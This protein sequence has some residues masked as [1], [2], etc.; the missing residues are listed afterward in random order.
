MKNIILMIMM[1]VLIVFGTAILFQPKITVFQE[2][3]AIIILSDALFC[4]IAV[5]STAKE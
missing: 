3:E 5:G 1:F 4:F 2:L